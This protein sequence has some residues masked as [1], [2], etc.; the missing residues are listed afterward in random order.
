MVR[1]ARTRD[2]QASHAYL[3]DTFFDHL[4][5]TAADLAIDTDDRGSYRSWDLQLNKLIMA[6]QW[7]Q[8]NAG[9]RAKLASFSRPSWQLG[10]W[11]NGA[12]VDML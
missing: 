5:R 6:I 1:K 7:K 2:T 12:E 10:D 8:R 3:S 4:D 9:D 11:R